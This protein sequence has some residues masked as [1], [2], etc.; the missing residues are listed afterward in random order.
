LLKLLARKIDQ[1]D[2]HIKQISSSVSMSPVMTLD[3]ITGKLE[4][5]Q[6]DP[7]MVTKSI[8]SP[9]ATEYPDNQLPF[10]EIH[11]AYLRKHHGVNPS[12]YLSNLQIMIK[13]R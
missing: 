1:N 4:Q 10:V 2:E 13:Q 8:Y 6:S 11:L 12:H 7:S 5:M 9:N 3:E